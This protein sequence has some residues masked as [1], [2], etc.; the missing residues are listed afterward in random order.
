MN[1]CITNN[2]TYNLVS[3]YYKLNSLLL[4]FFHIKNKN[5]KR[6]NKY[7]YKL[8]YKLKHNL[9]YKYNTKN[10]N[11]NHKIQITKYK[12]KSQI[13]KYKS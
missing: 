9:K 12:Y 11:T 1:Y 4:I 5:V 10:I 7:K 13:T 2:N 8:N 6:N 3:R